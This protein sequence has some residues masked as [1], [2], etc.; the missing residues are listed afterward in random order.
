MLAVGNGKVDLTPFFPGS[1]GWLA[2]LCA[3]PPR[4]PL[5]P[6]DPL[7][8][9]TLGLVA[10]R[11]DALRWLDEAAE[12]LGDDGHAAVPGAPREILR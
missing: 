9:A 8:L 12:P 7:L 5:D 3:A 2:A 11:R 1:G 6:G 10:L 4:E